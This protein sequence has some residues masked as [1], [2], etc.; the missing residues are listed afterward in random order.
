MAQE[1]VTSFHRENQDSIE[2]EKQVSGLHPRLAE[3]SDTSRS[4][5]RLIKQDDSGCFWD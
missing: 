4:Q 5:E 1:T 2:E 3:V